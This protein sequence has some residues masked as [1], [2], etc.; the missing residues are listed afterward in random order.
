MELLDH[1]YGLLL[2]GRLQ[3]A[4]IKN[5]QRVL[6]LGT[7]TGIWAIYF[8]EKEQPHLTGLLLELRPIVNI[9]PLKLLALT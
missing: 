9:L 4:P 1:I 6:D 8:A 5:P 7:G 3:L 2:G